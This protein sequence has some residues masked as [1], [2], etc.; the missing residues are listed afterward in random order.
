MLVAMIQDGGVLLCV[1][2][3]ALNIGMVMNRYPLPLISELLDRV[4]EARIFTQLHL[5]N[6]YHL[7]PIKESDEFITGFWTC[8]GQFEYWAIPFGLTNLP[9]RIQD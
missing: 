6:A 8:Y 1:D 5:R 9:A 7:I 3:W 2:N 4:R